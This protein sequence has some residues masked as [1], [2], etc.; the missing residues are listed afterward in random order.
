MNAT[1]DTGP[2]IWPHRW[3]TFQHYKGRR[4]PW[5]KLHRDILDNFD[6]ACL[7][8]ASKAL[9]P[10]LWLLASEFD[11]GQIPLEPQKL[12]WRLHTTAEKLL[13]ALKPL[14]E[15]GFFDCSQ[16]ASAMLALCK[17]EAIAET[18]REK[19]KEAETEAD[20]GAKKIAPLPR[21]KKPRSAQTALAVADAP[22]PGGELVV[23]PDEVDGGKPLNSQ[24]WQAYAQAYSERYG[25]EPLRNAKINGQIA[26]IGKQLGAEAPAVAA[27]Y[28]SHPSAFYV[29]S[30]HDIGLLLR[31]APGLRTQWA[32]NRRT[33]HTEALG[34]EKTAAR[35]AS[36]DRLLVRDG[37]GNVV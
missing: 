28:V 2:I 23:I 32:T 31:D 5:I 16:D 12:A 9:A 4:P 15:R 14:I 6:F 3:Q 37:N 25:V 13:E 10:C 33:T 36:I 21:A 34:G 30:S 26:Q 29:R 8:D 17:Q 20:C 7:P 19:E 22:A 35:A 11:C 18:E 27:F 1:N 24:I